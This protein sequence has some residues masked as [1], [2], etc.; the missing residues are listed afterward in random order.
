MPAAANDAIA[1]GGVIDDINEGERI[2]G[3]GEKVIL[4]AVKIFDRKLGFA[5]CRVR[6]NFAKEFNAAP[7][8]L[9]RRRLHYRHGVR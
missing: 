3:G 4:E 8:L 1:T 9:F 7:A 5:T 6:G 2:G